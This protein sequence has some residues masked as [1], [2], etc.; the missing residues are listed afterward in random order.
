MEHIVIDD[1]F[2]NSDLITNR[3]QK[4]PQ[5]A[6]SRESIVKPSIASEQQAGEN[7]FLENDTSFWKRAFQALLYKG[8]HSMLTFTKRYCEEEVEVQEEEGEEGGDS[9]RTTT[10]TRRQVVIK[11]NLDPPVKVFYYL[12]LV[13]LYL[14]SVTLTVYHYCYPLEEL[15]N[16]TL[17]AAFSDNPRWSE[18]LIRAFEWHPSSL[19]CA[20]ALV[21]DLIYVHS[22]DARRP[23]THI[24]VLKN[25][26]QKGVTAMAW[27]PGKLSRSS[28][29]GG[30][31]LLAVA[32]A[33]SGRLLLW[34]LS[35]ELATTAGAFKASDT[36]RCLQVVDSRLPGPV[37]SI[38]WDG[39]GRRLVACSPRSSSLAV[40]TFEGEDSK[41]KDSSSS[42]SNKKI[43][44]RLVRQLL[45][46]LVQLTSVHWAPD[47]R[48]LLALPTT[49]KAARLKIYES[50]QWS[51]KSW[52]WSSTSSTSS[53]PS[54]A[55]HTAAW[56]RPSGRILL[57]AERHCSRIHALTFYDKAEEGDVGGG[58]AASPGLLLL[59][60]AEVNFGAGHPTLGTAIQSI[61]WDKGSRRLAVLFE[62]TPSVIALFATQLTSSLSAWPLATVS[63]G[64]STGSAVPLLARFH[65][66][67]TAEEN[68]G[69]SSS[70]LTVCWSHGT[71]SHILLPLDSSATSASSVSP[72]RLPL[73][74]A[75]AAMAAT[76]PRSLST[77]CTSFSVKNGGGGSGSRLANESLLLH[78]RT[79][80][81]VS[82]SSLLS[83]ESP[84]ASPIAATSSSG[85]VGSSGSLAS[86]TPFLSTP[87]RP[88]LF[89]TRTKA[90]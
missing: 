61:A 4:Y 21:N 45:P 5:I 62:D 17:L 19:R 54:V 76:S 34:T 7:I 50:L 72:V 46:P 69:G 74:S 33:H 18:G 28:A 85:A 38:A 84:F 57:Y 41:D 25:L 70:L 11:A 44:V 8:F 83:P 88:L 47:G 89:S 59:D 10:T 9:S 82:S 75:S 3:G 30:G 40:L 15:S 43:S 90:D 24:V 31:H 79:A 6:I 14:R 71:V 2:V 58:H 27:R 42:S 77:I 65:D 48:R 78:N 12:V 66:Q 35:E 52:R 23:L 13:L 22:A 39:E 1:G 36:S 20:L 37:T 56:S 67:Y 55:V 26:A 73:D 64:F 16:A 29:E 86:S 63:P 32:T 87:R 53:S 81:N 68:G 51:S 60:T 49:G 80:A